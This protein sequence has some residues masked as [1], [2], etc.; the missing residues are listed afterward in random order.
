[1]K[2]KKLNFDAF[3]KYVHTNFEDEISIDEVDS[4][5]RLEEDYNKDSPVSL[6]KSLILNR[7]I[8]SGKKNTGEEFKYDQKFYTGVNVWIADNLKGKS[9][10]FKIVKYALTGVE[11]IKLDVK[12]WIDEIIL[13][14]NIAERTYTMFIDKR[15]R[16]S[17]LLLR[18]D[19]NKFQQ[20]RDA[21]KLDTVEK[22]KEFEFK[23]KAQL[24]EKLQEF[25]FEN[26]AFYT[27]KYT[28]K[29]SSKTDFDLVTNN[30]SWST[31]FKSIYLES[32][33]YEYLFFDNEKY[34]G[35]GRKIFEMILGLRLT[36]PINMLTLQRDRVLEE[37]GKIRL[38]DKY[39]QDNSVRKNNEVAERYA[40]VVE[41]LGKINENG[42]DR[43]ND[44]N[45]IAEYNIIKE[46]IN[47]ARK[48][49]RD[50]AEKL[51]SALSKLDSVKSEIDNF[52]HDEISI[53]QE[54]NRLS[55]QIVNF[56]LYKDAG[57]FFSNLDIRT[58][59][60][61][62]SDIGEQR[63]EKEKTEHFCSLCGEH[64]DVQHA[65]VDELNE[66]LGRLQNERDGHQLKLAEI[67]SATGKQ[68]ARIN[69]FEI[70]ISN[71]IQQR[72]SLTDSEGDLDRLLAIEDELDN[73]NV[74]R[75]K[76]AESLSKKDTLMQEKA[77]LEFQL[78][79]L[80]KD[81]KSELSGEAE[82]LALKKDILDYALQ[83][84][85]KKRSVTN[86]E[87]LSKLE[88]LILNEIHSFGLTNITRIEIND[89]YELIFTQNDVSE[90]FSELN[91]GEKLRVKLA[92]YLSLIQLDV[93]HNL[94][95]HP[96]FLIFDS[97]G[98]EEM[99]EEHLQGL[100]DVLK[101]VNRRFKSNLQIFVGSA[102]REFSEITEKKK[103]TIKEKDEFIF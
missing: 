39:R 48:S 51:N 47:N 68:R 1:M 27:L 94:G 6:G 12:A 64:S 34:G 81:E 37:I 74:E 55:K 61:C 52:Q 69:E 38:H 87:I 95:R 98:S 31:Y 103:A 99:I 67:K 21:Q 73:I 77:V 76:Q 83:G 82:K 57:S 49:A 32:S 30:L 101:S 93:E 25:F 4:I 20:L 7:L 43:F 5:L 90:H 56:E 13:E 53:E 59:P 36:Y 92:F 86:K 18:F 58:C 72:D 41:E 29:T 78:Q 89:K 80:K 45:L 54:V 97:P 65:E 62:E 9:T 46:K 44:S 22:E 60:H 102:L 33:N 70:T 88:A 19:A 42:F 11:S 100:S 15:G 84:L 28:S 8:F 40:Q 35:Q 63:K 10:I 79:E 96:R 23:S 26:F 75:A 50:I 2:E 3:V 66:K 24:E 85:E 91:E 71:L 17:G 16:D 14:F